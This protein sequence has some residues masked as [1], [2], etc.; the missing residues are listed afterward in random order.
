M[1]VILYHGKRAVVMITFDVKC[2]GSAYKINE[3]LNN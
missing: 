1:T 3:I 2:K